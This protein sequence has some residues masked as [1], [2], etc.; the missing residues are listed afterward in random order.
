MHV[1]AVESIIFFYHFLVGI[2]HQKKLRL[3]LKQFKT[4]NLIS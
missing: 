4:S 2:S 3:Q 1:L